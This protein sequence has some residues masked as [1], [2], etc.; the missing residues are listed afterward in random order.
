VLPYANVGHLKVNIFMG[1]SESIQKDVFL[2]LLCWLYC[3][4]C[5][6]VQALTLWGMCIE[7]EDHYVEKCWC[8]DS[9]NVLF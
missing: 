4:L 7:N 1:E 2:N 6:L 5:V 8:T 3:V 9:D